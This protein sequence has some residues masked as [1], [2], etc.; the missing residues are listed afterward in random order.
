M[1]PFNCK[2]YADFRNNFAG[3]KHDTLKNI[4]NKIFAY[5]CDLHFML[6]NDLSYDD[7]LEKKNSLSLIEILVPFFNPLKLIGYY[8]FHLI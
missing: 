7:P 5:L 3:G 1:K 2:T 4:L 8:M 6:H